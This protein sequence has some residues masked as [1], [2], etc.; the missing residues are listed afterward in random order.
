[1]EVTRG[2]IDC[3][4][5]SFYFLF[6][7]CSGRASELRFGPSGDMYGMIGNHKQDSG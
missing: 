3:F 1:M 5:I 7:K 2:R 6:R 4:V